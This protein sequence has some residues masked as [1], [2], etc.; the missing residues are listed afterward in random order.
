M[1]LFISHISGLP[2]SRSLHPPSPSLTLSNGDDLDLETRD[3]G[4]SLV[5]ASRTPFGLPPPSVA[6]PCLAPGGL[7]SPGS[8]FKRLLGSVAAWQ[9]PRY[10]VSAFLDFSLDIVGKPPYMA[11]IN[12]YKPHKNRPFITVKSG[13]RGGGPEL[14]KCHGLWLFGGRVSDSFA[15]HRIVLSD[16]F[17]IFFNSMFCTTPYTKRSPSSLFL[18]SFHRFPGGM[19]SGQGGWTFVVEDEGLSCCHVSLVCAL[20]TI[21][22]GTIGVTVDHAFTLLV[23]VA[24]SIGASWSNLTR[25]VG[26]APWVKICRVNFPTSFQYRRL[27]LLNLTILIPPR[28]MSNRTGYLQCI[29]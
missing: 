12:G 16:I 6:H 7:R 19:A 3:P 24:G 5:N 2:Y 25:I 10:R 13:I 9:A 11:D 29:V 14:L 22:S 28:G 4:S 26:H 27:V 20:Q 8:P 15:I 18:E 21:L 23:S 17:Q 1:V